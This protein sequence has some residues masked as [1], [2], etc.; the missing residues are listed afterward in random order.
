MLKDDTNSSL[1]IFSGVAD[2]HGRY[3]NGLWQTDMFLS[4]CSIA[5]H[6]SHK[7]NARI[8]LQEVWKTVNCVQQQYHISNIAKTQKQTHMTIINTVKNNLLMHTVLSFSQM[9]INIQQQQWAWDSPKLCVNQPGSLTSLRFEYIYEYSEPQEVL[10]LE[11]GKHTWN[12]ATYELIHWNIRLRNKTL[13]PFKI[14]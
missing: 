14:L 5:T 13:Q 8:K 11:R 2:E 4:C 12:C 7:E 10:A 9:R 1:V 3:L 6:T